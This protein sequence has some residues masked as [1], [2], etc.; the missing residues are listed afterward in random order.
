MKTSYI[1]LAV[2][3]LVTLTG[4]VATDVLLK[5][6][7]QKID[8]SNPY[9]T[10]DQ[11]DFPSVRNLVI[12]GSPVSEI[13]I[14]QSTTGQALVEPEQDKFLRIRQQN[15][16]AY[17]AFTPDYEGTH[18]PR[19]DADY[20]LSIDL[21]LRLPNL[22]SL[23]VTNGRV[24]LRKRTD[25]ALIIDLQSTRLRTNG[26]V[27]NGPV[28]LTG[29]RGSVAVLGADRY[30]SLRAVVRD[31]SGIQLN[32]TQTNAFTP[33]LSPRAEVQLRG[34]ALRWLNR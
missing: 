21:V 29:S 32:N 24:T 14:E 19:N 25:N 8:W 9:Q 3:L 27:V 20:E 18:D 13:V 4:M 31:S 15:D 7:Y 28:T 5:Q 10:S 2:L 11:R 16:T 1:L 33:E 30:G 26:V 23:R 12:E 34:Q 6:Q 17:I 22:Q